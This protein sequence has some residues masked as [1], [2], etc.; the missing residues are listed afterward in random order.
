MQMKRFVLLLAAI[1]CAA[2]SSIASA[3]RP[4]PAVPA[5]LAVPDGNKVFLV[6][7]ATGV[8]I[9]S[10]NATATGYGWTFVAPRAD[11]YGD[12]GKL[13]V[14]HFVGPTWLAKDGS[15]VVGRV[16]TR[17]TVDSTAIP[18]LL[19]VAAS[20]AGGDGGDRLAETTYIQRVA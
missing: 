19:L 7:H 17:A 1:V 2:G 15:S 14:T 12:N 10:C 20:T 18:W 13:I 4:E 11:L 6:G 3:A 5:G 16:V 8:Q 9:Y